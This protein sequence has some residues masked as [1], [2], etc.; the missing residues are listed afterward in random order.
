MSPA[1]TL[2]QNQTTNPTTKEKN[3][4]TVATTNPQDAKMTAESANP[5][6]VFKGLSKLAVGAAP[7]PHPELNGYLLKLPTADPIYLILDGLR[8]HVPDMPTFNN[9][10]RDGAQVFPEPLLNM[11]AEGP[12]LSLG[13]IL[14]QAAPDFKWY[15]VSNGLKRWIPSKTIA[16]LYQFDG[17]KVGTYPAILLNFIPI[18]PDIPPRSK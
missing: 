4:T 16:D 3:M 5:Q 11:V 14:A 6:E 15:L 12:P 18:G 17:K 7:E 9:L 2:R 13:A 8:C 1:E 10:F